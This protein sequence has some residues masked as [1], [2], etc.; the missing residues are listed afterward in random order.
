MRVSFAALALVRFFRLQVTFECPLFRLK[1]PPVISIRSPSKSNDSA[2]NNVLR[3]GATEA[4]DGGATIGVGIAATF[5]LVAVAATEGMATVATGG[6]GFIGLRAA[7]T[8]GTSDGDST[9]TDSESW[10]TEAGAW[11]TGASGGGLYLTFL[12]LAT[13]L[14]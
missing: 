11:G 7:A 3:E 10:A 8:G 1:S 2:S 4:T 14:L 9:T 13:V 6:G 5:G 12:A